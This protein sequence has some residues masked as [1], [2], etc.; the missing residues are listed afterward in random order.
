METVRHHGRET[1][2]DVAERGGTG[3][4]ICF[5]HGSGGS[6]AAWK[7]QHRLADR[8]PIVAVDLSGH[9]DSEDVDADP[10]YT[11]LSA[12][13]DDVAAVLEAT[14]ADVLAGNSLGGAV[15]MHLLLEREPDVE[16][17]VLTGTGAKLGVLQDLLEWLADDFDRAVEFLHVDDRLFHDP[18]PELREESIEEMYDC[19]RAVTERD[20]LTCHRF[21]VRDDLYG[22]DVPTLVVYGEHDQLTPPQYHEYLANE[23]DDA[24]LVELADAAH[25]TMLEQPAAFNDAVA[26]FLDGLE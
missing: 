24:E 23:I 22:I 10:G 17:A 12:Y 16:A 20:F 2:Y 1:A 6:R 15:V 18:S 26:D 25:L 7:A 3:P 13:A 4:T 14:D 8:Y 9:G 19:G 11:T 5:V 21:D